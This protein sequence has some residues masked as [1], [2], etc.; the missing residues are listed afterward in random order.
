M[1][2]QSYS[3]LLISLLLFICDIVVISHV[4]PYGYRLAFWYG[5]MSI[6]C[7]PHFKPDAERPWVTREFVTSLHY[8]YNPKT[9]QTLLEVAEQIEKWI[10]YDHDALRSRQRGFSQNVPYNIEILCMEIRGVNFDR[11]VL[12]TKTTTDSFYNE[13]PFTLRFHNIL[14]YNNTQ[15][16]SSSGGGGSRNSSNRC[17]II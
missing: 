2:T 15:S 3:L 14:R 6:S 5:P 9:E 10:Q 11:E 7:T 17:V 13:E 1:Q 16:H 12:A 4:R 8:W